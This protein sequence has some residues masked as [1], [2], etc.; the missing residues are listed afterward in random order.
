MRGSKSQI[1]TKKVESKMLQAFGFALAYIALAYIAIESLRLEKQLKFM[2]QRLEVQIKLIRAI[3][4][5]RNINIDE[6]ES[7]LKD[8]V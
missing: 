1:D 3:G 2:K 8:E 6:I 7:I 5:A 4:K